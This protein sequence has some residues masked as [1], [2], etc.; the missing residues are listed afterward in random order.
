MGDLSESDSRIMRV[1]P[2]HGERSGGDCIV[3]KQ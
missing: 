3:N 2:K 1:R